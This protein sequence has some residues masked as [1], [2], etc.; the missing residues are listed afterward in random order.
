MVRVL[1]VYFLTVYCSCSNNL[2]CKPE[3]PQKLLATKLDN[4]GS[5][6]YQHSILV[7]GL[8]KGCDSAIVLTAV[9]NYVKST[10]SETPISS[11]EIFNSIE[12]F[13]SGET[14][15][16]PKDLYRDCVVEVWFDTSSG[17]LRN[18]VFFDKDGNINFEGNRWKP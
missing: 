4:N 13:D 17:L 1:L 10:S 8:S 11:V 12:H 16:Q 9:K 2:Q 14:L 5:I 15:S 6:S 3:E 18:F 7:K